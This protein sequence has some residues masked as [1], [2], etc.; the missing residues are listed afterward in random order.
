MKEFENVTKKWKDILCS[1]IGRINIVKISIQPK[2]IY[3]FN[4][5]PIKIHD[6]FHQLEQI[7]PKFIWNHK[8]PPN[9]RS[10]LEKKITNLEVSQSLT[11]DYCILQSY[12]HQWTSLAVQWL[13]LSPSTTGGAGSIPGWGRSCMP[14]GVA[15]K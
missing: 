1:W 5:I 10:N 7:I 3:R 6:I 13:R 8:R 9:G 2:A 15:K 14:R 11:S 4:A 12:S